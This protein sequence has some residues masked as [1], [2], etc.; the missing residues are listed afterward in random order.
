MKTQL[1]TWTLCLCVIILFMTQ[2]AIP[3]PPPCSV[4]I[5][6]PELKADF[7]KLDKA[8]PCTDQFGNP[9]ESDN[10]IIHFP[11][12]MTVA[13]IQSV[14]DSVMP[15]YIDSCLCD[16]RLQNWRWETA[17][18]LNIEE[19]VSQLAEQSRKEGTGF[20]ASL[21]YI[22]NAFEP[23]Q[24]KGTP[25]LL[26]LDGGQYYTPAGKLI[27][28]L[29]TGLDTFY[30]RDRRL[31]LYSDVIGRCAPVG[32]KG[33]N[34]IEENSDISDDNGHGTAVT[35][36]IA[37]T[38][39]NASV[40]GE[41]TCGATF[42]VLKTLNEDGTG[43]MFDAIC[44]IQYAVQTGAEVINMSW[45]YYNVDNAFFRDS[46][47]TLLTPSGEHPVMVTSMGNY[48]KKNVGDYRHYP[49]NYSAQMNYLIGV[50]GDVRDQ[51]WD[52][53]ANL[54]ATPAE[55]SVISNYRRPGQMITAPSM[56][57]PVWGL[58]TAAIGPHEKR[59]NGTSYSAAFVSAVAALALC[60]DGALRNAQVRD[61]LSGT[62]IVDVMRGVETVRLMNVV[63][64]QSRL[65]PSRR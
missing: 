31:A 13:Q 27:A 65:C 24:E 50:A 20:S 37:R 55:L 42:L 56:N 1:F 45:G 34:F 41:Y 23:G 51:I 29:D 17:P 47:L 35:G 2:C 64:E 14:R 19:T 52:N 39:L 48:G 40:H 4:G 44:A 26:R 60:C 38:L 59:A 36:V 18:D 10:L 8:G 25:N 46:I 30:A 57:V 53:I 3:P 22:V 63:L 61:T 28:I 49:S 58:T 12:G 11:A 6:P 43:N 33:W 7:M 15:D 9:I 5:V 62:P 16:P 32:T 21:N 54:S